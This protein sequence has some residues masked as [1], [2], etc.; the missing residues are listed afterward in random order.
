M[1]KILFTFILWIGVFNLNAQTTFSIPCGTT[2]NIDGIFEASEWADADTTI[3]TKS[4]A[5]KVTVHM[6]HD[7]ANL[8]FA[9][10][11]RMSSTPGYNYPEIIL[12]INN[13]K[14]ETWDSNDF[15]FHVSMLVLMFGLVRPRILLGLVCQ[16]SHK[17]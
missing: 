16:I 9:F 4:A 7:T 2:P 15:W 12:D 6:K 13:E 14:S 1:N 17:R 8:Y 10:T 5:W 3:I 11:G